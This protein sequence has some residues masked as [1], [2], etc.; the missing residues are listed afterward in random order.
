[1]LGLAGR[2]LVGDLE[3]ADLVDGVA[4]ELD[5][6]RVLLRRRNTSSSPPRTASS[7][8]LATISTRA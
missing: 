3:D 1:V 8:R 6:Q 7:P 4:E 5:P 2:A